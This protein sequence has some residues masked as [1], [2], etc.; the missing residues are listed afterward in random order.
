MSWLLFTR[1]G[2]VFSFSDSKKRIKREVGKEKN[3]DT[4][5]FVY[6]F[7]E[8]GLVSNSLPFFVLQSVKLNYKR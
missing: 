4:F 2:L 3:E 1:Q 6:I 7:T 8:S 5:A